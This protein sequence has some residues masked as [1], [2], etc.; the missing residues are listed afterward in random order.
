MNERAFLCEIRSVCFLCNSVRKMLNE[1]EQKSQ[2]IL[3][4]V[5]WLVFLS[6][7]ALT[8]KLL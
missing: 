8:K 7:D 4:F 2:D 5:D 3:D 6:K 1:L